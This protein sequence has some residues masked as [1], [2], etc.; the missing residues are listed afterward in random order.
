[1]KILFV[2]GSRGEWGYIRPV[3]EEAQKNGHTSEIWACNMSVLSR[4]GQLVQEIEDQGY[5]VRHK[6]LTAIDGDSRLAMSR[7]FGVTALSFADFIS[8]NKYD[9]IIFSGDRSEQ[10]AAVIVAAM[11]YIPIAHIQAGEKSGNI[12]GVSRHAI[13]RFAHVHFA[14][15]EDAAIRLERSGEE[16]NRIYITGAPQL[17]EIRIDQLPKLD[18]LISRK[19]VNR[20]KYILAVLHGT[21]EDESQIDEQAEVLIEALSKQELPIIWIGSNNDSG[22]TAIGSLVKSSLR[23]NDKFYVNLNRVDYLSLLAN[24]QLLIGNSSSGILEAPTFK[25]PVINLGRRQEGR[26]KAK[27]VIQGDFNLDSINYCLNLASDP[28]FLKNCESVTNPYGDGN[29]SQLVIEILEKIVPDYEFLTKQIS[30]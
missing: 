24:S 8:N 10:L 14:S 1:M 28:D 25:T 27:N 19:V 21:T 4:F 2:L 17:D 6:S 20:E 5:N 18:E 15:N 29:S 9:W 30:Y 23:L 12:D 7:S 26:V 3:I 16:R 13:A 11:N 22:A